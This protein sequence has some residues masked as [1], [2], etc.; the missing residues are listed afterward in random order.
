MLTNDK[1]VI[2]SFKITLI[3]AT[4]QNDARS[5]FVELFS[6][7]YNRYPSAVRLGSF[8][9]TNSESPNIT[10]LPPPFLFQLLYCH[11]LHPP[12]F[13]V[14]SMTTDNSLMDQ[15]ALQA[16]ITKT[17]ASGWVLSPKCLLHASFFG[18]SEVGVNFQQLLWLK[19]GRTLPLVIVLSLH[20][21]I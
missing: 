19:V 9:N 10:F 21:Q 12:V 5:L 15:T 8:Y 20:H 13:K 1:Y 2:I 7:S 11:F 6:L 18:H 4:K 17:K 14:L 3:D 16:L